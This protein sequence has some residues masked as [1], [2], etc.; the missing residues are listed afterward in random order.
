MRVVL[1]PL[2]SCG[3]VQPVLA[4]GLALRE[5]GHESLV[6]AAPDYREW[7]ERLGLAFHPV[8]MPFRAFLELNAGVVTLNPVAMA[9]QVQAGLRDMSLSFTA[10][11]ARVAA[12]ADFLVGAGFQMVAGSVAEKL[13]VPYRF[14]VFC[15]QLLPSTSYP[16]FLSRSR[17]LPVWANRL[18]FWL[19]RRI[20]AWFF[21]GIVAECRRNLGLAPVNDLYH[22]IL[23][24][25]VLL[26]SDEALAKVP[27][28]V[29]CQVTQ[30]GAWLLPGRNAA[31][32]GEVEH[33]LQAGPPPVYVGFGSMTDPA[34]ERTTRLVLEAVRRAGCR[35]LISRGWAKLAGG[36]LPDGC[37]ALGEVPHDV[38]F[39]RVAA[40][41]HH[42]G[43]G[44]TAAASRAGV[45]QV[46]VPH[47]ADQF[48]WGWR[49]HEQQAGPRPIFR[50]ALTAASLHEALAACL[51]DDVMKTR[52]RQLGERLRQ[53]DGARVAVH[54]L[55]AACQA[56]RVHPSPRTASSGAS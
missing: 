31:L 28:D 21:R 2:G 11:L 34:P 42:G 47:L 48:F 1:A 45:P 27:D 43:A 38:L 51:S 17:N 18:S 20:F 16:A 30:T 36:P 53:T 41:V 14:T 23:E 54:H 22:H 25:G 5:A 55:E 4:L 29:R 32:P 46:V 52:A 50:T 39:P 24:P 33:F 49:V 12:G 37:L 9:R 10:E 35:A 40:I 8:G 56:R 44:T 3:D 19:T 15:P 7:A 13:G 6:C 26:A